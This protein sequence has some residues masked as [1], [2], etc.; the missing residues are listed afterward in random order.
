MDRVFSRQMTGYIVL[1]RKGHRT[2]WALEARS[3]SALELGVAVAV[4]AS[5]IAAT[6]T[7]ATVLRRR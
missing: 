5:R 4:V 7:G 1:A 3:L 2:E 6:A